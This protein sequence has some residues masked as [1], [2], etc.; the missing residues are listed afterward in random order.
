MPV[1][2]HAYGGLDAYGDAFRLLWQRNGVTDRAYEG[3]LQQAWVGDR[4]HARHRARTGARQPVRTLPDVC[5][6]SASSSDVRGC[7]TACT[8]STTRVV[9][10]TGTS[11]AFG[12]SVDERPSEIFR[13]HFWV[14]PFPEEDIAGLTDQ[15]GA[16]HVLFGSDW[17]HAEG[18]PQPADYAKYLED[19]RPRARQADPP[20]QR[21]RPRQLTFAS[22]RGARSSTAGT[23]SSS[24]MRPSKVRLAI[25]SSATSG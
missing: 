16:D 20:R 9:S 15:I 22:A 23:Y 19:A 18:T 3:N 7:R 11:S 12:E 2:Y 4:P 21:A 5:A 10:S 14:S 25:M 13:R 8:C 1:A 24:W 6:S 17:P